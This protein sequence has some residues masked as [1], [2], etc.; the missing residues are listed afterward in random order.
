MNDEIVGGF[1]EISCYHLWF[2]Q[3]EYR[4]GLLVTHPHTPCQNRE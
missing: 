4:I 1:F 2:R 3:R